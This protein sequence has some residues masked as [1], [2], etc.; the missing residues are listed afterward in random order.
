MDCHHV[1]EFNVSQL[2]I[3]PTMRSHL[4]RKT[5]EQECYKP[6]HNADEIAK[7]IRA[8]K[9]SH[10]VSPGSVFLQETQQI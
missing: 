5:D 2:A 9:E 7:A 6:P 4:D 1:P 3:S 10:R 8:R